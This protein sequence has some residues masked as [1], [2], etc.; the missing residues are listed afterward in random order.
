MSKKISVLIGS[1]RKD[2]LNKK[3]AN[4]LIKLAPTG[5][6]FEILEIGHL[7]HY[8][9]DLDGENPPQEWTDFRNKIKSSDGFL[10]L[11]PEYNRSVPSV[12]KNAI[13]IGSRPY[14]KNNWGGRPGAVI[15]VSMSALGAFGA[16]HTLRQSMVFVDVLLM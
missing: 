1:L 8:N 16:N 7:V 12:L 13:D 14:G 10:F 2:S 6:D 4:E 9:E 5:L 15:S 3:I 11:T